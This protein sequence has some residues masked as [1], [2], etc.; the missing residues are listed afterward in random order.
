MEQI[1]AARRSL[2]RATRARGRRTWIWVWCVAGVNLGLLL[3]FVVIADQRLAAVEQRIEL[4]TR[5][6]DAWRGELATARSELDTEVAELR[7]DLAELRRKVG[8]DDSDLNS[9]LD[10]LR[11]RLGRIEALVSALW[12]TPTSVARSSLSP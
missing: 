10:A 7:S 4:T 9:G 5:G 6:G 8:A 2:R 1:V 3:S 11:G 12:N